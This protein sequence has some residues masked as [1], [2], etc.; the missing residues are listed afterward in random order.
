MDSH[1]QPHDAETNVRGG[2]PQRPRQVVGIRRAVAL[3][4]LVLLS[5]LA[6]ATASGAQRSGTVTGT[7]TLDGRPLPDVEVFL[8]VG[9]PRFACTDA[10]GAFEFTGV[11]LDVGLMSATGTGNPER[12]DNWRS[13]APGGDVLLTQFHE[14]H[15][16]AQVLDEFRVTAANLG[17]EIDYTPRR[18][19]RGELVCNGLLATIEGTQ[20]ADVL[21][22]GPGP[23]VIAGRGGNDTI[24][25]GGGFD[26]NCG[27]GGRDRLFGGNDRLDGGPRSDACAGGR[28]R[29]TLVR[30]ET[31]A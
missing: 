31:P 11:P 17:F 3:L 6:S 30:C 8:R 20:S 29:D 9:S 18:A 14:G 21:V 27:Q 13:P 28:G 7:V 2:G 12:C 10:Q 19:A 26:S 15:D 22:G 24:R 5:G 25:G 23:D 4:C 1:D 16:G